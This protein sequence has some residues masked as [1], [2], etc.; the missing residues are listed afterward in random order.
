MGRRFTHPAPGPVV[1]GV[2]GEVELPGLC[3]VSRCQ[4][5]FDFDADALFELLQSVGEHGPKKVPAARAVV[6]RR[7]G[8]AAPGD[9]LSASPR[10]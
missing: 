10:D 1:L 6:C 8:P 9:V 5:F 2:T 3:R 4:R 7:A